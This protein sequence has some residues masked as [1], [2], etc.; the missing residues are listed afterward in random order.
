MTTNL[1]DWSR[2]LRRIAEPVLAG[3]P[4]L[5]QASLAEKQAFADTFADEAGHRR[6]WDA[7]LLARILG[8]PNPTTTE[9]WL[10]S[11]S[12]ASAE[13][14]RREPPFFALPQAWALEQETEKELAGLHGWSWRLRQSPL[15]DTQ[16]SGPLFDAAVEWT[17]ANIQ[18]DNATNHPW[19][20]HV[21]LER[22][23]RAG[24]PLS[25]DA[26]LYAETMLHNTI[27][28]M[29]RPDRFSALILWDAADALADDGTSRSPWPK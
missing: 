1:A 9:P 17:L 11:W 22:A 27:V 6:V 20:I 26:R 7:F 18:P 25:T 23:S 28:H 14:P 29:G 21:F 12:G 4:I 8:L 5:R 13:P 16:S 24:D 3:T 2:R 19:A 15:A 10:W